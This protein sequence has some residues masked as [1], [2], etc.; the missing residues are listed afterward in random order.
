MGLVLPLRN[1]FRKIDF[2]MSSTTVYIP[3]RFQDDHT[4]KDR[5]RA[6]EVSCG[7]KRG[8]PG[9]GREQEDPGHRGDGLHTTSTHSCWQQS[10]LS[11]NGQIKLIDTC[12]Y[13]FYYL[14][15]IIILKKMVEQW[16]YVLGVLN[17]CYN[18]L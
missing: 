16:D 18:T 7:C 13:V 14:S 11:S 4:T 3:L 12:S 15:S 5:W 2:N 1:V 9:P 10:S 6:L 8:P 17:H